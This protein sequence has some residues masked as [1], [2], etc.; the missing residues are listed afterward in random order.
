[1]SQ[2]REDEPTTPPCHHPL[3]LDAAAARI[4]RSVRLPVLR[5]GGSC[6]CTGRR[7]LQARSLR[8]R[9]ARLELESEVASGGGDIGGGWERPQPITNPVAPPR[10]S[11]PR[12]SRLGGGGDRRCPASSARLPPWDHNS[13]QALRQVRV[14]EGTEGA[15]PGPLPSP[16]PPLLAFSSAFLWG[17]MVTGDTSQSPGAETC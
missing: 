16:L 3:L 15:A 5:G 17:S 7:R 14:R 2:P 4:R 10:R 13:R 6:G 8:G 12:A 9:L 1:M 11:P